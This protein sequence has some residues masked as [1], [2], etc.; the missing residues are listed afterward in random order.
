MAHQTLEPVTS[1]ADIEWPL[2]R[3]AEIEKD[4]GLG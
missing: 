2:P 3:R 4:G 1:S